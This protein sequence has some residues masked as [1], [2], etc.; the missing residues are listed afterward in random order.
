VTI[1]TSGDRGTRHGQGALGQE[2][3]AAL[4]RGDIDLAVH[5]AKDVP[6]RLPRAW[7]SPPP[8]AR[9]PAR[10]AL[11]R[12]LARRAAD[13]RRV[14]TASLRRAAQLRARRDDLD[15]VELRGN[16]DTRLRRLPAASSTPSSSPTRA[17]SGWAAP[18]RGAVLDPAEIV[19]AAGQGTL[20]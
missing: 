4:L 18:A 5:S 3:D 6:A 14:G 16:V 13:G 1:T 12:R 8:G 17:C 2:I 11:R 7:R 20:I 15:V 9:R 19:P 10:R